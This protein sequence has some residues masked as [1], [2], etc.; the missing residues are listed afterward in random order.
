MTANDIEK[1]LA[2][3][4][5]TAKTRTPAF[6]VKA[7]PKLDKVIVNK[8]KKKEVSDPVKTTSCKDC[9]KIQAYVPLKEFRKA[10]PKKELS[11]WNLYMRE[12]PKPSTKSFTQHV[13]E[14]S[15]KY[16]REKEEW[17]TSKNYEI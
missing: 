11:A 7:E 8:K 13:R 9:V 1:H 10:K 12:H 14:L 17:G 4:R 2:Q 6:T 16:Q 3:K 5:K 15:I